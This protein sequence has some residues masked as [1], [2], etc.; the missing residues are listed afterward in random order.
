MSIFHDFL[1]IIDLYYRFINS[2]FYKEQSV[3]WITNEQVCNNMEINLETYIGTSHLEE[4]KHVLYYYRPKHPK[5]DSTVTILEIPFW[6]Y[7]E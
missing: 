2:H 4:G 7:K 6:Y 1:N 5:T 3:I